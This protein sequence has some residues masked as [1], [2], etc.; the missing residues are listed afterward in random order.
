[1]LA[2]AYHVPEASLLH[3]HCCQH[4]RGFDQDELA[5]LDCRYRCPLEVARLPIPGY[6]YHP[7]D[8]FLRLRLALYQCWHWFL[9]GYAYS[10]RW[11]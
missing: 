8:P 9:L 10:A 5:R 2:L 1:M 6:H 4:H 11:P 7:V 3:L